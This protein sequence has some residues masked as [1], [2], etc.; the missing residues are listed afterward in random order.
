MMEG[1]PAAEAHSSPSV[2]DMT[3]Y[4]PVL[5]ATDCVLS[6]AA[7]ESFETSGGNSS[8]HSTL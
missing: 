3:V 2:S 1:A 5:S 4:S 7:A 6:A 8:T